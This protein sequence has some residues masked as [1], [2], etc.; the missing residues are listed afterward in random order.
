MSQPFEDFIKP[1]TEEI[2]K[3]CN[4]LTVTKWECEDLYQDVM[5]K[6]FLFH[7]RKGDQSVAKSFLYRM[8]KNTWIDKY[9]RGRG[10]QATVDIEQALG[11]AM[12]QTDYFVVRSWLEDVA[13][14]ISPKHVAVWLLMD[15]F[16]FS[17][18][19]IS[20]ASGLTIPA[21][22]SSLKRTRQTLRT[23]DPREVKSKTIPNQIENWTKAILHD[24]P[25][26][27]FRAG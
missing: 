16:Q 3:Y 26:I 8:T 13:L 12:Y 2:R 25:E 5:I 4:R 6:L 15:Y 14:K 1:Y 18:D 9:R 19:D 21:I 7:Q 27:V 11:I 10:K 17:M 22:K 23:G 20:R 24:C